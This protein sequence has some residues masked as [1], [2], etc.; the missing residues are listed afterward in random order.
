MNAR[1][2]AFRA[3]EAWRRR[4][5]RPD[6]VLSEFAD[7]ARL[8]ERDMALASN[9]T[10]GVVQNAALLDYWLSAI[11]DR[12]L[13]RIDD[14]VRDILRLS[15]YQIAFLDRVP[16]R[17]AVSE[18]VELAKRRAPRAS[19]LVNALLR[20][21][22]DR[23]GDM[24]AVAAGSDAERLSIMYSHP[25]WLVNEFISAFGRGAAEDILRSDNAPSPDTLQVNT[26]KCT[27]SEALEAL[28]ADG[29]DAKP[30]PIVPD[31]LV[32]GGRGRIDRLSAFE[33][34][35]VWVQDGAANMAVTAAGVKPGMT[36]LDVCGAP[37]GKSFAAAV[38]ME[39][40]GRII[41]SDIHEKKLSLVRA[42]AQKL[43]IDIIETM[44][45]DASRFDGRFEGTADAVIADVPCSGFGVI[46]KKPE[47][48]YKSDEDTAPLPAVQRRILD[49]V[50]RYVKPGGVLVYSTCTLLRRE[51]EDVVSAFL[52]ENGDFAAESFTLPGPAGEAETGMIT[53]LPGQG[54]TDGFFICR[55]RRK[56]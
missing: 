34:G 17:A 12:G 22:A 47:I 53:L 41:T 42:G 14:S 20:R 43:G 45:A 21:A 55:M 25:L 40:R 51:N 10:N 28:A 52:A 4:D 13:S 39:N 48:R 33:K 1:E 3:L 2:A 23:R 54:G 46:A 15:L 44:A 16:P 56:A 5:A 29:V 9:I 50:S 18:G 35:L 6:M 37:G 31:A 11:S 27:A 38:M 49:N 36:V 26:L 8:D 7:S 32:C 19:G 30:H 24:P